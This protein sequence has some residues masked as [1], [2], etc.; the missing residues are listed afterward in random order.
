MTFIESKEIINI[1]FQ[2]IAFDDLKTDYKNPIDLCQTLNPVSII[3][4]TVIFPHTK[5]EVIF[6]TVVVK[7]L[8]RL[9]ALQS[10]S[11]SS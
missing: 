4:V 7:C 6:Y 1:S 2:V 5:F 8:M 9:P 10:S 11:S 3:L